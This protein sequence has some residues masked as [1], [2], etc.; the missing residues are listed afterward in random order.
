MPS[1]PDP[2]ALF[3]DRFARPPTAV[4]F[5]PGRVNL[6]GEH[7][8][9]N[10]GFVLPLAIQ[11]GVTVAARLTDDGRIN[12]YS[13]NFPERPAVFPVGEEP[14]AATW[15][16]YLRALLGE[17]TAAGIIMSGLEL[18][19]R[20]DVPDGAGL[21]SSAAFAVA[22]A[23][24]VAQL[25]GHVWNDIVPLAKICQAAEHRIGVRCGL[26]DQM[27]SAGCRAGCAM[28]LDCRSMTS[29]MIPLDR[30]RLAIVLGDTTV[31]RQLSDGRYN[32]RRSE[33]EQAAAALGVASLR[34]ADFLTLDRLRSRMPGVLVRRARHVLTENE[35]VHLFAAALPESRLSVTGRLL[36]ESH[37]SLRNDYEVSCPEL[38]AMVVSLLAAGAAGAR[39]VGGGFGGAALALAE[40]E[41]LTAMIERAG[42]EY[43]RRT[44]RT[45]V[46]HV[47]APGDGAWARPV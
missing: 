33:C 2:V 18:A 5:A 35:R 15:D 14:A 30:D 21:S 6:I 23:R 45:G 31:R 17:L 39:L 7:T 32:Q 22:T 4:A 46:F 38:D 44:G 19:Y 8:D 24:V 28:L 47:V 13:A 34:D 27:A 20:G 11:F 43:T 42:A 37:A 26:L 40:P 25:T 3:R 16:H 10:D 29:D 12:A 36:D 9:Y 41:R 1:S